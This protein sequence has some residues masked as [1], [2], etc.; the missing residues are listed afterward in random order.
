LAQKEVVPLGAA[1]VAMAR[2]TNPLVPAA[3]PLVRLRS[4]ARRSDDIAE[5]TLRDRVAALAGGG[6]SPLELIRRMPVAGAT[7][8]HRRDASPAAVPSS[9]RAVGRADTAQASSARA[10]KDASPTRARSSRMPNATTAGARSADTPNATTVGGRS[11]LD[12]RAA[13]AASAMTLGARSA[14]GARP[15]GVAGAMALGA[16]SAASIRRA[17]AR[18]SSPTSAPSLR[19]RVAALAGSG[20]HGDS[21]RRMPV[22]AP[23]IVALRS[24]AAFWA[25]ST[26]ASAAYPAQNRAPAAGANPLVLG[27]AARRARTAPVPRAIVRRSS[28]LPTAPPSSPAAA[29][30][31]TVLPSIRR[32]PTTRRSVSAP[33]PASTADRLRDLV[34]TGAF[35]GTTRAPAPAAAARTAAER[36]QDVIRR[37]PVKDSPTPLPD[38]F[39]PLAERILGRRV[40]VQVVHG[41]VTRRAL[42]AA[43]HEA[44]TTD[45]T[46]HLPAR[47][48]S[49]ARTTSIV[50]H[51]LEHVA[52][53]SPVPRFHGG[54][55]SPEEARAQRTE[56]VV[57]RLAREV[58]TRGGPESTAGTKGLPVAA[59]A[60][61]GRAGSTPAA[62]AASAASATSA[63]TSTT[64]SASPRVPPSALQ[65]SASDTISRTVAPAAA[66]IPGDTN[67][68]NPSTPVEP[69]ENGAPA[70]L[71]AAQLSAIIR[72]VEDRLLEE[73]ERR[74]GLRRGAF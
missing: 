29:R 41:G 56:A 40:A 38:R 10:A 24:P 63:A 20:Q 14:L 31:A 4:A 13:T 71:S 47:P 21:V 2:G 45:R 72:A 3:P 70:A 1:G 50:A 11:A 5:P 15:A 22:V 46:I 61:F 42:A 62:S 73:I 16:R 51:E 39:R 12:P 19:D 66:S 27:T 44:A 28:S 8:V 26:P 67:P 9:D 35:E 54:A 57:R 60:A 36:F 58:E 48:D 30:A 69:H 59:A 74:G 65:R 49:S 6:Q 32:A 43:G 64:T 33:A 17:P 18:M 53:R 23:A 34:A 25:G 7:V 52:A 37:A 55:P 68:T